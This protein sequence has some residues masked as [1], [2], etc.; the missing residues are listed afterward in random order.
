M[1]MNVYVP[2][3]ARYSGGSATPSIRNEEKSTAAV[4][5]KDVSTGSDTEEETPAASDTRM[6]EERM[7]N[8]S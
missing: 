7:N 4:T 3:R 6:R 5:T 2:P 8:D 1:T